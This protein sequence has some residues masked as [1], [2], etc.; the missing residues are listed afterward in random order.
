MSSAFRTESWRCQINYGDGL[1]C[2]ATNRTRRHVSLSLHASSPPAR[3]EQDKKENDLIRGPFVPSGSC[4]SCLSIIHFKFGRR[5]GRKGERGCAKDK[6]QGSPERVNE[7]NFSL[8]F[9]R[10][11]DITDASCYRG[12]G[13]RTG[14]QLQMFLASKSHPSHTCSVMGGSKGNTRYGCC[15]EGMNW[16]GMERQSEVKEN[17]SGSVTLGCTGVWC[18]AAAGSW[19]M[20]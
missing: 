1:R 19:W 20:T 8:S 12:A 3:L 17:G 10:F 15:G 11:L 4:D 14:A 7:I 13:S 9:L 2:T 5:V 16:V 6:I 18:I